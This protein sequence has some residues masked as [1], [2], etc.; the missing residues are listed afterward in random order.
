MADAR[1][2]ERTLLRDAVRGFLGEH[3]PPAG[4]VERQADAAALHTL[5]LGLARQGLTA[6]G[7]DDELGGVAEWCIMLEEC[8]RAA[9]PAPL[10][11]GFLAQRVLR[12][13]RDGAAWAEAL[14]S[15]DVAVALAP[16]PAQPTIHQ[17]TPP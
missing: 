11:D 16:S 7:G 14:S 1:A 12:G 8:G 17:S 10:L 6:L 15:G 3:W 9:C 13:S 4:A 2:A 5:W